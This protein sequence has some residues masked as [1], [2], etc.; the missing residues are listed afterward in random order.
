MNHDQNNKKIRVA[1]VGDIH[2]HEMPM[3]DEKNF[4]LKI[5]EDADI[6]ILCGDI[7]NSGIVPE[8]EQLSNYL[9][10]CKIPVVA[11]LG[12]HDYH[13]DNQH[14]IKKALTPHVIFLEDQTYTIGALTIIGT[15][16]FGGGF[17]NHMLSSFG[18]G[19]T[20]AFVT[21]AVNESLKLEN[22]LRSCTTKKII[23]ALHYS[24]IVETVTGEPPEIFPF[25]GCSRLADVIDRFPVTMVVHGHAHRGK[26]AGTT[27]KGIPVYN[28]AQEV[29]RTTHNTLYKIFT[30]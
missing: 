26:H 29:L 6:L 19:A 11:V 7:T 3:I 13:H 22:D 18:E 4:F 25:L 30:I 2:I 23:V 15:K 8:A 9:Q 12:N 21:E 27:N 5:S 24:P 20:K 28:C 10:M 1:V 16:G 14:A 17:D